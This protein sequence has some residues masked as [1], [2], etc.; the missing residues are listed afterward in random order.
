MILVHAVDEISGL[1]AAHDQ[2]KGALGDADKE[3]QAIIG[4]ARQIDDLAAQHNLPSVRDN[5]YTSLTGADLTN[6]WNEVQKLV[7]ARDS[8]LQQEY[9]RQ[10][11]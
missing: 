4:I 2:F 7:P 9:A 1:T 3:Y 6:K 11:S 10:Q 5:P 8:A